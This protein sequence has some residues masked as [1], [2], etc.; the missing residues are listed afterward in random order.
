MAE[1]VEVALVAIDQATGNV[2]KVIKSFEQLRGTTQTASSS[3]GRSMGTMKLATN[4]AFHEMINLASQSEGSMGRWGGT[5]SHILSS[6]TLGFGK[7]NPVVLA[8]T[9]AI[10]GLGLSIRSLMSAHDEEIKRME[11]LIGQYNSANSALE[12]LFKT[13]ES[14][15]RASMVKAQATILELQAQKSLIEGTNAYE[16]ALMRLIPTFDAVKKAAANMSNTLLTAFTKAM[17]P[18]ASVGVTA[19]NSFTT[20]MQTSTK[21]TEKSVAKMEAMI[22]N[23]Q[24]N[25]E[26]AGNAIAEKA[27]Q[28][29]DGFATAGVSAMAI[30]GEAMGNSIMNAQ[31]AWKNGMIAIINL[32]LDT[33]MRLVA[34][35]MLVNKAISAM[36][37]P[38]IGLGAGLA[39][40]AGLGALKAIANTALTRERVASAGAEAAGG[41]ANV[42]GGAGGRNVAGA[43][44]T[45]SSASKE[46]VNNISVNIPI[47]ALD[48]ASI[49]DAQLKGLSFRVGKMIREA[50]A[51]GQ[52][53]LA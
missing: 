17:F 8:V 7:L 49:S 36:L 53:S 14:T 35:A 21:E 2:N 47:Q 48:L 5:V 10:A 32:F 12:S 11:T 37:I 22:L 15:A 39:A 4:S 30:V 50:A 27:K 28:S 3:M 42:A 33:A 23:L 24:K 40:M 31:N 38:G 19:A 26:N 20:A 51:T 34:A 6:A 45:V 29:F 41:G 44:G 13:S 16:R 18:L 9:A 25:M 52:F 1:R 43:T 46:V